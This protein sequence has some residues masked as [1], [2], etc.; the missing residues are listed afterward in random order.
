MPTKN[1]PGRHNTTYMRCSANAHSYFVGQHLA[2]SLSIGALPFQEL[3]VRNMAPYNLWLSLAVSRTAATIA[4]YDDA[5]DGLD[6]LPS[7]HPSLT[8]MIGK[9]TKSE[10]LN[11]LAER[12]TKDPIPR[13]HGQAYLYTDR[14]SKTDAPNVYVDYELQSWDHA[15]PNEISGLGLPQR[16]TI[17]LLAQSGETWSRRRVGNM[18][19]GLGITPLCDTVCYFSMDLGGI[20]AVAASIAEHLLFTPSAEIPFSALPRVLVVVETMARSFDAHA[21]E[22]RILAMT[23]EIWRRSSSDTCDGFASR[24]RAHYYDIRVIGLAKR[25]KPHQRCTQLRKRLNCIK[26]EVQLSR[27]LAGFRYKRD[28]LFVF[29]SKLIE[30]VNPLHAEAFSFISTSRPS[31]F[32]SSGL[33]SHLEDLISL[34]PSEIWLCHLVVPLL[35]SGLILATYPPGSHGKVLL[36]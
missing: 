8:V 31:G 15:Q 29:A 6:L 3:S 34:V 16:H 9:K 25:N 27:L 2:A 7:S 22:A 35:S 11:G 19:C 33:A 28:H 4:V 26:R 1:L 18:I 23:E 13:L 14:S 21:T 20:R 32:C 24:L 30:S 36:V 10:I 5:F 12:P 17:D